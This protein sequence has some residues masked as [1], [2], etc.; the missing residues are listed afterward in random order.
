LDLSRP[1]AAAALS[2]VIPGRAS[3]REPGIDTSN[4]GGGFAASNALILRSR[5]RVRAKRG[6]MIN[7]AA[8]RRMAA[9]I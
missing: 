7:S 6:P 3:W 4:G 1:A 8:S 2:F 5:Q 9:G